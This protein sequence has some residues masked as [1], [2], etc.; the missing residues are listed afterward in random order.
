V[1]NKR[2][3]DNLAAIA[4]VDGVDGVFFGPADL[5]A[6]LGFLG[7]PGHPEVRR[8]ISAGIAAVRAAGKAPLTA[9][10]KLAE[11]YLHDGALFVAVGLDTTLLV[12][13]CRDLVASYKLS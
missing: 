7:Q 1:E 12:R 9:D 4:A 5:L 3:L 6:S 11:L 8:A 10:P 13:A 2:G